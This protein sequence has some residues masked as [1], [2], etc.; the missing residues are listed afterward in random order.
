MSKKRQ[1]RALLAVP[2]KLA[3]EA[4]FIV[5]RWADREELER[6]LRTLFHPKGRATIRRR[7]ATLREADA[8]LKLLQP[9]FAA[10]RAARDLPRFYRVA[11]GGPD[12]RPLPVMSILA[13][14]G[15]AWLADVVGS[16]R[17]AAGRSR[18]WAV[19]GCARELGAYFTRAAGRPRW[20][21]AYDCM[22]RR[23]PHLAL[24][25]ADAR[26][27]RERLTRLLR[28]GRGRTL[29]GNIN[30]A[31]PHRPFPVLTALPP[32]ARRFRSIKELAAAVRSSGIGF[33]VRPRRRS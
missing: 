9:V 32:K 25:D 18:E 13:G 15:L 21:F 20:D 11:G 17:I 10:S 8:T 16:V 12:G 14:G 29:R 26:A 4:R 24:V 5:D 7:E 28:H 3:L 6:K 22:I 31:A 2:R 19:E 1:A 23:W 33:K 27:K 30:L